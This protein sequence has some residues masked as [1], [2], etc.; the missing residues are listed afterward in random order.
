MLL[1]T[2]EVDPPPH[3]GASKENEAIYFGSASAVTS[4]YLVLSFDL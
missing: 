1:S 3:N 4:A 2:L